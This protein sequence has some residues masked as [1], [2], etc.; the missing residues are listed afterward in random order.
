MAFMPLANSAAERA[1]PGNEDLRSEAYLGLV[2]AARTY[3]SDRGPFA[4][5]AGMY[6]QQSLSR[7]PLREKYNMINMPP[8][9]RQRMARVLAAREQCW[10][11]AG[12]TGPVSVERVADIAQ[13]TVEDAQRF[14]TLPRAAL[15]L[16]VDPDDGGPPRFDPPDEGFVDETIARME[17]REMLGNLPDELAKQCLEWLQSNPETGTKRLSRLASEV[18]AVL[19]GDGYQT[20]MA[21]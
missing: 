6:V 13:E 9:A 19:D 20:Q 1:D 10:Q 18:R 21:I 2:R 4:A 8:N 11:E 12:T 5:W 7:A 14:L 15:L 16:N 3:R 17:V